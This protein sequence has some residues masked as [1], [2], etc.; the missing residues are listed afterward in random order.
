MKISVTDFSAPIGASVTLSDSQSVL[1]KMKIKMLILILPSF[2]QI[3]K[4]SF[5]HSYIIHIEIL[6]SKISQQL[7]DLGL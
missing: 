6:L 4:F 2:F 1:C 7:L 5:C 3:F